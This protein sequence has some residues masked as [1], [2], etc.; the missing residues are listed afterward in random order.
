MALDAVIDA[1]HTGGAAFRVESNTADGT[2]R[3]S[4]GNTVEWL[5][6]NSALANAAAAEAVLREQAAIHFPAV[7]LP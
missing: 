4:I 7:V 5:A 1:L 3:V 2:L 6:E